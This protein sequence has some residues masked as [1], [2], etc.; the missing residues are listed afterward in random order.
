MSPAKLTRAVC[1]FVSLGHLGIPSHVDPTFSQPRL[2]WI[3]AWDLGLRAVR[4]PSASGALGGHTKPIL[5]QVQRGAEQGVSVV[6]G[7]SR[8]LETVGGRGPGCQLS[9]LFSQSS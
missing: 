6:V 7:S 4:V 9:L 5:F 2:S 8:P 3:R 1:L